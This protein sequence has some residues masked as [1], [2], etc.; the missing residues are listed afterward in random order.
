M[1]ERAFI[2]P[3]LRF[4]CQFIIPMHLLHI[5]SR[6][7][8]PNVT[9]CDRLSKKIVFFQYQSF[10]FYC[11]TSPCWRQKQRKINYQAK[12]STARHSRKWNFRVSFN[13]FGFDG[14]G[15]LVFQTANQ[16]VRSFT[17][18]NLVCRMG[19]AKRVRKPDRSLTLYNITHSVPEN[20]FIFIWKKK[21]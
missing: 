3:L 10:L 17:I 5:L 1:L 6:W 19:L 4:C 20:V 14:K 15:K 11:Y 21:I 16:I 12:F 9:C 13:S 7:L 8:S 18:L 2:G